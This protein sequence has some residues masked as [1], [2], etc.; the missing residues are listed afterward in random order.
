VANITHTPS[1]GD[2]GTPYCNP[3]CGAYDGKRCRL[4]GLRPG[5]I[6]EPAVAEMAA[7]VAELETHHEEL[8]GQVVVAAGLGPDESLGDA[9]D[10]FHSRL[11]QADKYRREAMGLR[12]RVAELEALR[13]ACCGSDDTRGVTLSR[14]SFSL[15]PDCRE[16][17]MAGEG[18]PHN[19]ETQRLKDRVAELEAAAA[20]DEAQWSET[21]SAMR[22]YQQQGVVAA[23][24][25]IVDAEVEV[26]QAEVG[27]L[28]A[29]LAKAEARAAEHEEALNAAWD[30]VVDVEALA[31]REMIAAQ[32]SNSSVVALRRRVAELEVFDTDCDEP[33]TTIPAPGSRWRHH[34]GAIYT[35]DVVANAHADRP[36]WPL[37]VH[38]T[39]CDGLPWSRPLD[40]F[41][42]ACE[43]VFNP[44][45][46]LLATGAWQGRHTTEAS[47]IGFRDRVKWRVAS[48]Q[49]GLPGRETLFWGF[50]CEGSM[51]TRFRSAD[52]AAAGLCEHKGWAD[53]AVPPALAGEVVD[54]A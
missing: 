10:H 13:C 22:H 30:R 12:G 6:C 32:Q 45:H 36:G 40:A 4:M 34:S 39:D 11:R 33:P 15:C 53:D 44:T 8:R 52:E 47:C 26:L 14:G 1:I 7:R 27:S 49:A 54:A 48:Y 18:L 3:E 42:A 46:W 28:N 17:V 29:R 25:D 31:R 19:Y 2:N 50:A 43:P 21:E 37:T 24:R 38:Y 5:N 41:L 51:L 20:R 16:A 9:L 23:A 35:V